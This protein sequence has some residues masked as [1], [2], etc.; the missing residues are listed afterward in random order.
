MNLHS[1]LSCSGALRG[2]GNNRFMHTEKKQK[3]LCKY[4]HSLHILVYLP[5]LLTGI[6]ARY[7]IFLM[8]LML[9][10]YLFREVPRDTFSNNIFQK[11]WKGV[12]TINAKIV[13]VFMIICHGTDN[14]SC[15]LSKDTNHNVFNVCHRVLRYFDTSWRKLFSKD[16][17]QC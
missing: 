17:C 16:C 15:H 4:M 3:K 13:I 7:F 12:Y 9:Y 11:S 5:E 10:Y 8:N 6:F 2:L 1:L 14:Y